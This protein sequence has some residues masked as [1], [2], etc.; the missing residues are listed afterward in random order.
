[1]QIGI[2]MCALAGK[3]AGLGLKTA[4]VVLNDSAIL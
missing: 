2:M 3:N 4:D 1:L